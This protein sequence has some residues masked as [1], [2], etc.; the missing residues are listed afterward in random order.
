M[1][2]FRPLSVKT[3]EKRKATPPRKGWANANYY[4]KLNPRKDN[5]DLS[6]TGT[7]A[8]CYFVPGGD[9]SRSLETTTFICGTVH[10]AGRPGQP[11][12]ATL[13]LKASG[14]PGTRT[15]ISWVQARC[16]PVAP[17]AP[18]TLVRIRGPPVSR[19]RPTFTTIDLVQHPLEG[20]ILRATL[21]S[22]T[23]FILRRGFPGPD[24]RRCPSGPA[25]SASPAARH[26]TAA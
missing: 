2:D 5:R 19:T 21:T 4:Y 9:Q 23:D 16:L 17:A 1:R 22:R 24:R 6:A 7:K 11:Y 10:L 3:R 13:T 12:P 26:R 15:P 25:F 8:C 20:D 14:Q 18:E